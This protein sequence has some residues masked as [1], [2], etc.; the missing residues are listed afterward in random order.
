LITNANMSLK[1]LIDL[2]LQNFCEDR[3]HRLDKAAASYDADSFIVRASHLTL[4]V[5]PE[6]SHGYARWAAFFLSPAVTESVLQDFTPPNS[7]AAP[8]SSAKDSFS[9]D[10]LLCDIEKTQMLSRRLLSMVHP[11]MAENFAVKG[12]I[13]LQNNTHCPADVVILDLSHSPTAAID[14]LLDLTNG[15][16]VLSGPEVILKTILI[17]EVAF[18]WDGDVQSSKVAAAIS[19]PRTHF[20]WPTCPVCLH[21]IDPLRLGLPTPQNHQMCSKFCPPPNLAFSNSESCPQQRMLR[22]WPSPCR[23]MACQ[24]IDK[25]WKTQ[26]QEMNQQDQ[27]SRS[28]LRCYDCGLTE[29][30]WVCLTCGFLGCGRY[31]N[32]HSVQHFDETGHPYSLELATLRVWDYATGSFA[33]RADLLDC[34]SSPPILHPWIHRRGQ[35]TSA[36]G[37]NEH[38][39]VVKSPKKAS[40]IGEEYEAL[41]Q[42]ALEEQAQH[43]EGEMTALRARLTEDNLDQSTMTPEEAA[44]IEQLHLEAATFRVEIDKVGREL[45]EWQGKEA[46]HR[47]KSQS[48]LREQQIVQDLLNTIKEETAKEHADGTLQVEELEQQIADLTANQR[49]RDQFSQDEELQQA[50]IW[51]M[52]SENNR[53]KKGKKARRSVRK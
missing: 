24:T 47:A 20:D 41:L 34:P 43:Y 25:H 23:C 14:H 49:M 48:L 8:A 19:A 22:P 53:N 7:N 2:P 37:P 17:S 21:R 13:L 31:S 46:G 50:Q 36:H 40:M 1:L 35:A 52:T 26:I 45:L 10:F 6:T 5:Y 44:E 33:H 15:Q 32:K 38:G 51:G 16:T 30:L 11:F 39:E 29:T 3:L 4:S 12:V 28:R 18:Q 27:Y 9:E 42:S